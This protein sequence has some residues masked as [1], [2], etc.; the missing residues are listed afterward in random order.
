MKKSKKYK[1][2]GEVEIPAIDRVLEKLPE[3]NKNY[4]TKSLEIVHQIAIVL[5]EKGMNQKA[6][7]DKLNKTEPEVS[8]WLS[9][10]HNFTMRTI[11]AIETALGKE[12]LVVPYKVSA[13]M[14]KYMALPMKATSNEK[15]GLTDAAFSGSVKFYA[16]AS[17]I[18]ASKDNS[19][20]QVA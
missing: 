13:N 7:A 19:N 1:D 18:S 12:V 2:V 4:V 5:K 11:T 10:T 14:F 17:K 6:L 16:V 3:A 9:G 15:P 8:K 20:L